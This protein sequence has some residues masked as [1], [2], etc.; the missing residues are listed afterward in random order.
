M[1]IKELVRDINKMLL[2]DYSNGGSLENY[3][4]EKLEKYKKDIKNIDLSDYNCKKDGLFEKVSKSCEIINNVLKF[5]NEAKISESI[6][7][8]KEY[9]EENRDSLLIMTI[10]PSKD[11]DNKIWYRMRICEKGRRFYNSKEMF[12]IPFEL[13]GKVNTQRYSL[14]GYPCLYISRSIWATWEEMH[15]PKL[16][17]FC[18]SRL[19]LQNEI[20]ILDLR[21]IDDNELEKNHNTDIDKILITLPFIIACSIKVLNP[22]DNFKPE[23][24]IPQLIMLTL[25]TDTILQGCAY[26]STQRNDFFNWNIRKLDNIA[27]PVKIV[28]EKGLCSKLC[29]YFKITDSTSF[30]Y[31]LLK[32][33]FNMMCWNDTIYERDDYSNSIFYELEQRLNKMGLKDL[34]YND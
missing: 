21:I 19:E 29:S 31:E 34:K 3:L 22:N 32:K 5:Y 25:A 14:P 8:L 23:Y 10:N 30:D 9:I 2:E 20:N 6:S 16:S 4:K 24:I 11:E 18:V 27:L 15:E 28:N 33:P 7:K 1:N 13:R 26:T 12:H 17:D